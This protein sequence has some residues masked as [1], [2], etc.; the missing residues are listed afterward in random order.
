MNC[1]V[2]GAE[3]WNRVK[4]KDGRGVALCPK[5]AGDVIDNLEAGGEYVGMSGDGVMRGVSY[6]DLHGQV[7]DMIH[8][9]I[10]EHFQA[11]AVV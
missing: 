8:S 1:K 4:A 10:V 5:C 9:R 7:T 11:P 3:T 6:A 2:C